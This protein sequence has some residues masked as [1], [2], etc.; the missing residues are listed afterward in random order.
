[1][2][3]KKIITEA[4]KERSN[5]KFKNLRTQETTHKRIALLS[6]LFNVTNTQVLENIVSDFFK[7]HEVEIKDRIVIRQ[8]KLKDIF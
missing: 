1:M 6:E 3:L 8:D 7:I 2:S 5:K 4:S